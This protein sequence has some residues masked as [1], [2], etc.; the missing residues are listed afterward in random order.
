[1]QRSNLEITSELHVDR[2]QFITRTLAA[3]AAAGVVLS[4]KQVFAADAYT[5]PALPYGYDA[6]EPYIDSTTMTIHHTKH[7]QAYITKLNA[8]VANQSDLAQMKVEDLLRKLDKLPAEIKTA[9]QNQGGGHANHSL[10]WTVLGPNK[11]GNPSGDL[12]RAIESTFGSMDNFKTKFSDAATARFG[13]GWAWLVKGGDV[14]EV[15]STPNQDSP[16][17]QGKTPILGLDVWEHAYYLKY[18]NRRP[19]YVAAFWN[20]V[21]WEEVGKR[22][23]TAS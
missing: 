23:K 5:L 6:L 15:I 21:D 1:M 16:L 2:R 20:I 13:S 9:V 10:F 4:A 11:G 17:S 3:T 12:A 22:F 19:E 18:Q 8:A 14:L 7:H